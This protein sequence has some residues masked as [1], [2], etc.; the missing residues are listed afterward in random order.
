MEQATDAKQALRWR[1]GLFDTL[2]SLATMP[3]RFPIAPE[4]TL[5]KPPPVRAL[6]YEQTRGGSAWRVLYRVR[7]AR[8]T[9]GEGP[10]VEVLSIRYARSKPMTTRE[11]REVDAGQ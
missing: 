4:S 2:R 6:L 3:G 1:F 7:E 8:E 9:G 10:R 11:A 5:L